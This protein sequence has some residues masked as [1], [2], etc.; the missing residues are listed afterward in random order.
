MGYAGVTSPAD[1][2]RGQPEA[3]CPRYDGFPNR[4]P[5]LG[6]PPALA[7]QGNQSGAGLEFLA[8]RAE[9]LFHS[10]GG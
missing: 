8:R 4:H 6:V 1:K 7:S 3:C 2:R 5:A 10:G 9:A